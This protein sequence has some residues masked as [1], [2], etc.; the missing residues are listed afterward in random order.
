[1]A[2]RLSIRNTKA[3]DGKRIWR[4]AVDSGRLDVNSSYC[5]IM[6]CD[7]F[8][9]TCFVAEIDGEAAGFVTSF[10]HPSNP[11]LLFVWQM[12]V[13]EEHRGQGIAEL[14]LHHLMESESCKKVRYLE[15]TVSP[16]NSASRRVLSKLSERIG[17]SMVISKG[18][19]SVLF[20]EG[21]HEEE[22][23][24]RLGPLQ[25]TSIPTS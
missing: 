4:L 8:S 21:K 3:D 10:I 2:S 24:I 16:G 7:Y 18:Y 25:K 13:A 11:E 22:P 5:Y 6:L 23:L 14:L 15:T 19:T 12:A 20:P 9:D 17:T 1:M